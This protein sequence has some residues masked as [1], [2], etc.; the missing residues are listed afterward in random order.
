MY[1]QPGCDSP[2]W[3]PD[4]LIEMWFLCMLCW[5]LDSDFP[6]SSVRATW[7]DCDFSQDLQGVVSQSINN[8]RQPVHPSAAGSLQGNHFPSIRT[9]CTHTQNTHIFDPSTKL[10]GV[11]ITVTPLSHKEFIS[12]LTCKKKEIL[13]TSWASVFSWRGCMTCR[14][15]Y[16][17]QTC[18][19]P[20]CY[21][22]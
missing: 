22:V 14:Q 1:R 6:K 2:A 11:L 10:V 16:P 12:G 21:V 18:R 17:S 4:N 8:A 13:G 19:V 9:E 15:T 7:L 20:F 5:Q 3:C